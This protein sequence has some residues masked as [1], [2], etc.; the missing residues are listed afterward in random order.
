[1]NDDADILD[2]LK[3]T[4][5]ESI[6]QK[7]AYKSDNLSTR[8]ATEPQDRPVGG[9]YTDNSVDIKDKQQSS[10]K[11]LDDIKRQLSKQDLPKLL[12]V[13]KEVKECEKMEG[14]F[15]RLKE[16]FFGNLAAPQRDKGFAAK[17]RCLVDLGSLIPKRKQEE[18]R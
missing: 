8:L 9:L 3:Q 12:Q 16:L 18:Y 17:M 11:I 15:K 13:F 14:V 7:Y 4:P 5:M 6:K 10:A 1:M 2:V